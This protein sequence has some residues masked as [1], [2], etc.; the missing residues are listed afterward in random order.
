MGKAA[1]ES[2]STTSEAMSHVDVGQTYM[3]LEQYDEAETCFRKAIEIDPA[4]VQAL[5]GVVELDSIRRNPIEAATILVDSDAEPSSKQFAINNLVEMCGKIGKWGDAITAIEL[6]LGHG[7]ESWQMHHNLATCLRNVGRGEEAARAYRRA[8]SLNNEDP[9]SL[10]ELAET[11]RSLGKRF[12]AKLVYSEACHKFQSPSAYSGAAVGFLQLGCYR[13]AIKTGTNALLLNPRD[14]QAHLVVGISHIK[15]MQYQ[16]AKEP[17]WQA[18]WLSP[19][20]PLP[21]QYLAFAYQETGNAKQAEKLQRYF[22]Q[23]EA[24]RLKSDPE[25]PEQESE[26]P[27]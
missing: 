4:C 18:S 5:W 8:C 15:L 22:R 16:A 6:C 13:R 17:L 23:I 2:V 12:K 3:S 7:T 26:T 27:S 14:A 9:D 19:Q 20:N 25:N 24:R 10:L 21:I 11:Y 1:T